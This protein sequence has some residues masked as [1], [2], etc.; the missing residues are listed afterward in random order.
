M[1]PL[2]LP[3]QLKMGSLKNQIRGCFFWGH[4][5]WDRFKRKRTGNHIFGFVPKSE[6]PKHVVFFK[7]Y[8]NKLGNHIKT[9]T[10]KRHPL[11]SGRRSTRTFRGLCAPGGASEPGFRRVSGAHRPRPERPVIWSA[12][13]FVCVCASICLFVFFLVDFEGNLSL[14]DIFFLQGS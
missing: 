6:N 7:I 8:N 5:S 4:L 12:K 14:L 13:T 11:I 3:N 9:G 10:L 2:L 1:V